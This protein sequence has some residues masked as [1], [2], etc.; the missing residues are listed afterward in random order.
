ME[1]TIKFLGSI[2]HNNINDIYNI[3]DIFVS[4]NTTGNM[5]NSCLEALIQEF[6]VLFQRR[7]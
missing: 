2:T 3:S 6:V 7:I 5:S 4:L 1:N